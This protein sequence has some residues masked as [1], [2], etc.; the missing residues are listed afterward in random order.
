MR[1][2]RWQVRTSPSSRRH[3]LIRGRWE[4][5]IPELSTSIFVIPRDF[6][7]SA[8]DRYVVLNK[9]ARPVVNECRGRHSKL[10]FS[11]NGNPST[12]IYNSGW[13]GARRRA[14]PR[15]EFASC[16]VGTGT[17]LVRR[18]RIE[19]LASWFVAKWS[20]AASGS[21][22]CMQKVFGGLSRNQSPCFPAII[23]YVT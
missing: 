23:N 22:D 18:E 2:L 11:R 9:N 10:V 5:Q 7:K 1:S 4:S 20:G 13:K 14:S 15:Y 12:R 21:S 19:L 16:K 8:R 6:V 17:R 3:F